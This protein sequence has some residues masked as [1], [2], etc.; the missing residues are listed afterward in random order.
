MTACAFLG[1]GIMGRAMVR[2][3]LAAGHRVTVYN[4]SPGPAQQLEREGAA[5]ASSPAGSVSGAE[6]VFTCLTDGDAL[7]SVVLGEQGALGAAAA[8]TVFIDTS[9]VAPKAARRIAQACEQRGVAALDAPVSGGEQGAVDG[10]LSV[11]VGGSQEAFDRVV[12]LLEVIGAT[13]EHV[14]EAGAGQTVK[15]ANQL[16]VAGIY[17]LVSEA[18]LV[19]EAEQ[20]ELDPAIRV[21]VGGLAG[22]RVLELKGRSMLDRRFEPGARVD[23]HRKDLTIALEL[24]KGAGIPVPLTAVVGQLY[25]ALGA[26]GHGDLDHSAVFQLLACLAGREGPDRA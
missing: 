8:G 24:A 13:I 6:V 1:L 12:P 4:R 23:L 25:E 7:E 15:A 16:L 19:L 11:M 5:V 9:T 22:N 26:Q 20:V 10:S 17:T 21:L 2:N 3:L 18:L 14:G